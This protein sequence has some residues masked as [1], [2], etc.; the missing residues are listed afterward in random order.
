[1]RLCV[2]LCPPRGS[3][4]RSLDLVVLICRHGEPDRWERSWS[5]TAR[6]FSTIP[7]ALQGLDRRI[8]R[9][10]VMKKR[11]VSAPRL[12]PVAWMIPPAIELLG[13]AWRWRGARDCLSWSKNEER[14]VSKFIY[15]EAKT[16]VDPVCPPASWPRK[17]GIQGSLVQKGRLLW[18]VNA[19]VVEASKMG[20]KGS[21]RS[22][23]S[24]TWMSRSSRSLLSPLAAWCTGMT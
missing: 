19:V 6:V 23:E 16:M 9:E 22:P 4:S 11:L 12:V 15:D 8:V 5:N 2:G 13:L 20:A 18:R 1:M 17:A 24:V 14:K 10:D 3:T 7:S 21:A